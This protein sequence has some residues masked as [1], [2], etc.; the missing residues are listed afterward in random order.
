MAKPVSRALDSPDVVGP[1]NG[2]VKIRFRVAD[3][4]DGQRHNPH[5]RLSI[6]IAQ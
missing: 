1:E 5:R 6:Y 4:E 2:E 3:R